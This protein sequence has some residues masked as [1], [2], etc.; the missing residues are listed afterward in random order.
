MGLAASLLVLTTAAGLTFTYLLQQRQQRDARFAAGARRGD[1]ASRQGP[2][3]GRDPAAWRDALAALERAEG[4]GPAAPIA[5][6]RDEIQSG[7]DEAERDARLRQELVEIR[8]NQEDVGADGTDA[9]YASGVPRREAGPRRPRTG[10]VRPR[11]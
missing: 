8:A 11:G 6:L 10:R 7:L 1:G 9:A 5:A 4:Q 3:R 2:P